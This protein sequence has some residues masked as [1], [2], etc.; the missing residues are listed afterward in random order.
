MKDGQMILY[1][2]WMWQVTCILLAKNYKAKI[3]SPQLFGSKTFKFNLYVW[4]NK[5]NVHNLVHFPSLKSLQPIFLDHIQQY[6]R[7]IFL[8]GEE[9]DK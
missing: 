6:C 4:E 3:H 8:L 2:L 1:C 7:H 5:L 9:L